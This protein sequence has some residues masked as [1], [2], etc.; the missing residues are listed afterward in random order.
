MK[1]HR[2]HPRPRPLDWRQPPACGA[3]HPE[4]FAHECPERAERRGDQEHL[5]DR[6]SDHRGDWV[7]AGVEHELA[8][9]VMVDIRGEAHTLPRRIDRAVEERSCVVAA[10]SLKREPAVLC[11]RRHARPGAMNRKLPDT[12]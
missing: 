4:G 11:A 12:V 5:T 1:D 2:E 8:M 9:P 7:Q 10:V 6:P 3:R